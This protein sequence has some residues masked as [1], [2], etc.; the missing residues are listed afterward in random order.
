[1][2]KKTLLPIITLLSAFS[3]C[4]GQLQPVIVIKGIIVDAST[5]EAISYATIS[6]A[7]NGLSTMSNEN[8][9]FTLK[10][11][12]GNKSDSI[13]ISH[14]GYLPVAIPINSYDGVQT[15]KL[16]GKSEQLKEVVVKTVNALEL[17]KK[18]IAQIPV[19]YA[20]TPYILNGFYRMTGKKEARIIDL[21]EAVFQAYV[22]NGNNRQVKV[23]RSRLDED[24]TAF[25]GMEGFHFGVSPASFAEAD[26][27]SNA[28]EE[29]LLSEQGLQNHVFTYRGMADYGG[30][31]IR[32]VLS[33]GAASK[34][35]CTMGYY[36]STQM[37]LPSCNVRSIKVPKG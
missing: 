28:G 31:P 29:G 34:N 7:T 30:R 23:I 21:S 8:G 33:K 6:T 5:G 19:N 36:T 4:F 17:V 11:T 9:H 25:G 12:G 2:R 35:H 32:L 15:I 13:Y 20:G 14:I 1:M 3:C 10:I 22:E 26:I 27:V 16:L 24:F 37:I 18:A